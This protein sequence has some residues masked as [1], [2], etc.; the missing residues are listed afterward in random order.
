MVLFFQKKKI[1]YIGYLPLWNFL[2]F[3]LLPPRVILGPITGNVINPKKFLGIINI[4]III[5][6]FC[7]LSIFIIK[8]KIKNFFFAHENL[9]IKFKKYLSHDILYNYQ[10]LYFK[11]SK[12]N[13]SKKNNLIIYNRDHGSK[14]ILQILQNVLKL[15]IFKEIVIIGSRIDNEKVKN[16]GYLKHKKLMKTLRNFRYSLVSDEN[17]FSFFVLD[18]IS[19]NVKLI[20]NSDRYKF[21]MYNYFSGIDFIKLKKMKFNKLKYRINNVKIKNNVKRKININL[22]NHLKNI[23]I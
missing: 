10:L 13:L 12:K 5:I 22:N 21:N 1:I 3:L 11:K 19:N 20:F 9:Y 2:I 15:R 17:F 14:N 6:L 23:L 18:A 8:I 16:L 7:Y 4:K